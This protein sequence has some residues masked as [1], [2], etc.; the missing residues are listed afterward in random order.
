M[1]PSLSKR[2][3]E[4][5][6]VFLRAHVLPDGQPDQVEIR[7]S[8]GYARLDNAAA[9]AV[10]RARFVPRRVGGVAVDQWVLVPISFNLE[11]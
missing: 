4:T 2:L 9:E 11:N 6:K 5:G 10:R 7:T 3:G 1:Y 8:S